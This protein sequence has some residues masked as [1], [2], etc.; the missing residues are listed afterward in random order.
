MSKGKAKI[1][2]FGFAK[3]NVSKRIKN[4]STVGTPLYMSLELLKS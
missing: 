3:K 2:D 1:G 4:G